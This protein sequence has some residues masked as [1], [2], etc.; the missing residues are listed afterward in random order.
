MRVPFTFLRRLIC[1]ALRKCECWSKRRNESQLRGGLLMHRVLIFGLLLLLR[2][3]PS[4]AQLTIQSEKPSSAPEQRVQLLFETACQAVAEEFHVDV[5]I[6]RFPLTVVI[7]A[8]NDR[9]FC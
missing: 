2:L 8:E 5:K 9:Y 4:F 1:T 7:G 6:V 3:A